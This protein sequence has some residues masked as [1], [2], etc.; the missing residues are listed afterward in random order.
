MSSRCREAFRLPLITRMPLCAGGLYKSIS[1]ICA[2]H[3][4]N[5]LAEG[6]RRSRWNNLL[7]TD[8]TMRNL[9]LFVLALSIL[10]FACKGD[11]K[12]PTE[13]EVITVSGTWTGIGITND[14]KSVSFEFTISLN[15]S[16]ITGN[17]SAQ[18]SGSIVKSFYSVAGTLRNTTINL[19]FSDTGILI[20][21]DGTAGNSSMTGKLHGPNVKETQTTFVK[22]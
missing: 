3:A 19:T 1:P 2:A 13:P 14:N 4:L 22:K 8:S 15:G 10:T 11:D 5:P 16:T 20:F 12:K 18:I 7:N 17:G 9:T 21:F 6:A